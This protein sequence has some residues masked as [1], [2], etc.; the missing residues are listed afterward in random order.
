MNMKVMLT[1]TLYLNSLFLG[2]S[3]CYCCII[4]FCF[5]FYVAFSTSANTNTHFPE[6]FNACAGIVIKSRCHFFK[7]HAGFVSITNM[8]A[9][10]CYRMSVHNL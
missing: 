2:N 6:D 7:E 1:Q 4:M 5:C 10:E 8:A 9:D 3:V